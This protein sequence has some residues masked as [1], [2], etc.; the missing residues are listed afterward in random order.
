MTPSETLPMDAPMLPPLVLRPPLG[1]R[2]LRALVM[3]LAVLFHVASAGWSLIANGREGDLAAAARLLLREGTWLP[4]GTQ[5]PAG[6]VVVW[7]VKG[8]M[9]LFGTNEFG[10][11]F[12]VALAVLAAVWFTLRIGEHFGGPWR[13]FAASMLFLC[14]P[15][16]FTLGR[17][18]TPAPFETALLTAAFY[19]IL[20]GYERRQGRRP[21]YFMAWLAFSA[22]FFTGGPFAL[23]LPAG[24]FALLALFY[25]VAPLRLRPFF[26]WE[27]AAVAVATLCAAAATGFWTLPA[28]L[29]GP[30]AAGM[31]GWQFWMLF[32][33][34]VLLLPGIYALATRLFLRPARPLEWDEAV[35]LVWWMAGLAMI[36]LT[37]ARSLFSTMWTWPAFALWAAFRLEVM[38]RR[39]L[40]RM[41][42]TIFVLGVITLG[43]TS[44]A[45]QI[46]AAVFPTIADFINAIPGFFWPA[47][48]S[49]AF[50]AVMAF[51]LFVASAFWLELQNHR[52]FAVVALFGAMIPAGY[53]FADAAAKFAPY[54]SYADLARSIDTGPDVRRE[55]LIDGS[56][57]SASSLLFYLDPSFRTVA[58][59]EG[60]AGETAREP[61][62]GQPQRRYLVTRQQRLAHWKQACAAPLEIAC[63]SGGALLLVEKKDGD[64]RKKVEKLIE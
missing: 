57:F 50:I 4:L 14:N 53:A 26:S 22:L 1:P 9:N 48:T 34:S 60:A 47:I 10:A 32:P 42:M 20:R 56:R 44:H 13:G 46:L 16:M 45:R 8:S 3:G 61:L 37:P 29:P 54:F 19:F 35:P 41:L 33:W 27:G 12:P 30:G 7:L 31:A 59:P 43:I 21:W 17:T 15:G 63:Q 52:R 25:R 62:P 51:T 5:S 64:T 18:L 39:W 49:V 58:V 55:V 36:V 28:A 6:P 38:P 2:V 11:R 23:V 40:L 24:V